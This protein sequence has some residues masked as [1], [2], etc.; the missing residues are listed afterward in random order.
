MP[1]AESLAVSPLPAI[2]VAARNPLNFTE[3]QDFAGR[4]YLAGLASAVA[5][6]DRLGEAHCQ[7]SLGDLAMRENL[8]EAR[9]RYAAALSVYHEICNRLGEANCLQSLGDLAVRL[10]DLDGARESLHGS[11]SDLPRNSCSPRRSQLPAQP[12]QAGDA[13]RRSRREREN[14]TPQALPIFREVRDRLGE[15]NC[16]RSLGDLAMREEDRRDSARTLCRGARQVCRDP[17]ASAR[18]TASR[19]SAGWRCAKTI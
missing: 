13:R 2:A 12:R 6:E 4:L 9:E 7:Q 1:K 3:Q 5:Q 15:A 17:R 18:P 11:A 16:L 8:E 10:D 19:A 14:A